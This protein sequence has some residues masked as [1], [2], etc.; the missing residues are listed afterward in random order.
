[1]D[2]SRIIY[3][4]NITIHV[5]NNTGTASHR[6]LVLYAEAVTQEFPKMVLVVATP[7]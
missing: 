3:F 7:G 6:Y 4:D 1:M 5:I 2:E